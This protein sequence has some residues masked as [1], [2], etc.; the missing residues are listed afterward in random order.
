MYDGVSGRF[1]PLAK[2][3]HGAR[4]DDLQRAI[5]RKFPQRCELGSAGPARAPRRFQNA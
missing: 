4:F 5:P 1:V 3:F 2:E